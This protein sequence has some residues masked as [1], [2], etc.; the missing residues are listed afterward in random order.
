MKNKK[1]KKIIIIL[2]IIL[3]FIC[4]CYY[5]N[6]HIKLTKYEYKTSKLHK[7]N[8]YKIIQLSDFHNKKIRNNNEKLIRLIKD[9]KPDIIVITGDYID[10]NHTRTDISLNLTKQL[11]KI[12]PVYFI[13]GNHECSIDIEKLFEFENQLK[14]LGV[15]VL[16]NE[17]VRLDNGINLIGL[18]DLCLND[19]TL[20]KIMDDLSKN[21]LNILLAHEPQYISD[22]AKTGVDVVLSG[23]THGGQIRIPFTRIGIVA[24][25]QGMFPKYTAGEYVEDDTTMFISSGIGNSILPLR[26]FN[27][28]GIVELQIV[29]E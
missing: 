5:E 18:D 27:C 25:N 24:P 9:E 26:I 4:F 10:S 8:K 6:N 17:S 28:P 3:T 1:L 21:D 12:A 7:G 11:T 13:T 19:G 16:Y 23:H 20:S 15:N 22:Y 29:S 2:V 14:K